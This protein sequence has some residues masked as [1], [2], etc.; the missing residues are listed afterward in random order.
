MADQNKTN[1]V[2]LLVVVGVLVALNALFISNYLTTK[3]EKAKIEL[4]L[5]STEKVRVRVF[6]ARSPGFNYH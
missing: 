4:Q 6:N 3:S 1:K 2:L 5:V